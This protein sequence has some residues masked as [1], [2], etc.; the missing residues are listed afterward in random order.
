ME[1]RRRHADSVRVRRTGAAALAC[2]LILLAGCTTLPQPPERNGLADPELPG[3]A[4]PETVDRESA[5][6]PSQDRR[7][8]EGAAHERYTVVVDDIPARE[9]LFALAR[10]A[11]LQIDID[12]RI[13]GRVTLNAVEEQL[14]RLLDRI[15][16]QVPI[17][18]DLDGDHL[19][20]VADTPYLETHRVAYVNLSRSAASRVQTATRVGA[21]GEHE[22]HGYGDGGNDSRTELRSEAENRFWQTLA[23][24]VAAMIDGDDDDV[25]VHREAGYVTVRARRVQQ[26]KIARYLERVLAAAHRQVLIEA[27][28]VEVRLDDRH[29]AGVDWSR[30]AHNGGPDLVQNLT[31]G[32]LGPALAMPDPPGS[33]PPAFRLGYQRPD[34]RHGDLRAVVSM[35]D[36]FGDVRVMSTP[37]VSALNNQPAILKVVDNRVYFTVDVER[38]TSDGVTERV[39]ETR[40][41]TVPVGLVMSVLPYIH[42]DGEVLLSVRPTVSRILGFVDDPNPELAAA[43]VTNRI[44]EIQVRELESLLRLQPGETA[45]LGGLMQDQI[46]EIERGVP[47]LRHVPLLGAL[48]RYRDERVRKSELIVFLRPTTAFGGGGHLKPDI[49]GAVK[50]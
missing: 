44:P 1:R 5:P 40:V 4:V 29:Q 27:T 49:G 28:V 24:N 8:A 30:L 12:G 42:D 17:R 45:V 41:N 21:A 48:F 34:S 23:D 16:L 22:D 11:N 35:L 31:G 33:G 32:A 20:I 37:R 36:T 43:G 47:L 18:H 38:T 13:E 3:P 50:R 46:E 26:R 10:D 2:A 7:A 25:I 9:L 15:A 19:R 39:F 6:E 14:P